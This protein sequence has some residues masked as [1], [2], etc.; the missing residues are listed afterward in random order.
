MVGPEITDNPAKSHYH[1]TRRGLNL[2][3]PPAL[4][5]LM[6]GIS[7]MLFLRSIAV[8]RVTFV[9]VSLSFYLACYFRMWTLHVHINRYMVIL[10]L[11]LFSARQVSVRKIILI[12][13]LEGGFSHHAAPCSR[14]QIFPQT[15]FFLVFPWN[16]NV[17]SNVI[18]FILWVQY[19][20]LQWREVPYKIFEQQ[21]G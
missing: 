20:H 6:E 12:N 19:V 18:R 21:I 14:F 2:P 17:K 10:P 9:V 7:D 13:I 1:P 3:H 15:G 16:K 8:T 4:M 5:K 11:I